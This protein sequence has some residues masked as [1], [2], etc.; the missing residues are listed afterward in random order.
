MKTN[1]HTVFRDNVLSKS[2]FVFINVQKMSSDNMM[3]K[4]SQTYC[5]NTILYLNLR[6]RL[7]Q[8]IKW[9]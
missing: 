6:K 2:F 4:L 9:S 1:N 5:I 7:N 3:N 8:V